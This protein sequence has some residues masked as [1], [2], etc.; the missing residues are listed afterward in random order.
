MLITATITWQLMSLEVAFDLRFFWWVN[1]AHLEAN[2]LVLLSVFDIFDMCFCILIPERKGFLHHETRNE[3][4]FLLDSVS[5]LIHFTVKVHYRV[6][7]ISLFC[8]NEVII[9]MHFLFIR[10][11][12][13]CSNHV[14][15]FFSFLQVL[16]LS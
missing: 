1:S 10:Y 15:F 7:L 5:F 8:F 2:F 14:L 9:Y 6:F 13:P 16:I 3:F 12:Q 11:R 4:T